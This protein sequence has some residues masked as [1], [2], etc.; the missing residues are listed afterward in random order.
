VNLFLKNFK[1]TNKSSIIKLTRP[2]MHLGFQPP[3][4]KKEHQS[5]FWSQNNVGLEIGPAFS[6]R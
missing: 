4:S 2:G 3:K 5:S 6:T 1:F